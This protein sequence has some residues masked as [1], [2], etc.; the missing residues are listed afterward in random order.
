MLFAHDT[1]IALGEAAALVNTVDDDGDRLHTRAGLDAFLARHPFSG[2]V[3]G[4]E[5]ELHAVR[6]LRDRLRAFWVVAD[7]DET[8]GLVNALLADCATSPYLSKHDVYDWHLHVTRPEA[9]LAMRIGAEAAMGFL[10]L[11]RADELVR[12]RTC[13]ADDCA[14]VL[15]DLSR[16]HSKR[17]CDTGNCGNRANVAAYRARKRTSA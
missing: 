4:D 11:V 5:E 15:V 12:L 13:A 8:A 7:R 1:E 2:Q 6:R 16:N 10:D 3:T 17:Y 14:A 9:P